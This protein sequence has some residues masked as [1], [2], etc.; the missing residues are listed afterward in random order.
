MRVVALADSLSLPR[1]DVLWEQTWP[2]LLRQYLSDYGLDAEVINCGVRN[3]TAGSL[4]PDFKEHVIRK[5]PTVL[6]LQIG[7]VDGSPR[8]FKKWEYEM[9]NKPFF[10]AKLRSW[11]IKLRSSKRKAIIGKN[12]LARVYTPPQMFR[13]SLQDF[14]ARIQGLPWPVKVVVLPILANVSYME[15]KSPG[16]EA[17]LRVYNDILKS[18]SNDYRFLWMHPSSLLSPDNY[19]GY[20]LSVCG[21]RSVAL[22]ITQALLKG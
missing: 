2:Y 8:I 1:D 5:R 12:P 15:E 13:H 22:A 20:H 3:R 9:L 14:A 18:I 17:N 6:I 16:F 11:L 21:N 7:I 4:I 19:V 10:P